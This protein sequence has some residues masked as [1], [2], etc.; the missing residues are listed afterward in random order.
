MKRRKQNLRKLPITSETIQRV[1]DATK[2]LTDAD[3]NRMGEWLEMWY[4]MHGQ[5]KDAAEIRTI[6]L[7]MIAGTQS[8]EETSCGILRII[9]EFSNLYKPRK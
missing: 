9:A 6:R 5:V 1:I 7:K 3:V 2:D 4:M 8:D